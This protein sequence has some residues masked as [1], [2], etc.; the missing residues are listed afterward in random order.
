MDRVFLVP[1]T[2]YDEMPICVKRFGSQFRPLQQS[3]RNSGVSLT[4]SCPRQLVA[5]AANVIIDNVLQDPVRTRTILEEYQN[6]LFAFKDLGAGGSVTV[7]D[8]YIHMRE[9]GCPTVYMEEVMRGTDPTAAAP[10]TPARG[11]T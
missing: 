6:F 4:L 5:M 1:R 8:V 10:T 11:K 9:H 2:A 7:S 3:R